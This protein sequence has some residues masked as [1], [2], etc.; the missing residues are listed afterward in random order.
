[1]TITR[2]EHAKSKKRKCPAREAQEAALA[3]EGLLSDEEQALSLRKRVG[4]YGA[5]VRVRRTA[6]QEARLP[7]AVGDSDQ[8]GGPR[9]WPHL[10]SVDRGAEGGG[11]SHR[12]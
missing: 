10:R 3:C 5:Q 7:P 8:R 2:T 9:A 12:P 4:R 6:S 11:E 1:M